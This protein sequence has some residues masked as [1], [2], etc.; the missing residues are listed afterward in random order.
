[1]MAF[2]LDQQSYALPIDEIVQIIPMVTITPVPQV[3]RVVE[4]IINVHGEVLPV[5]N[6]RRHLGLEPIPRQLH[7]PILIVR[8][9]AWTAGLIVDEVLDVLNMPESQISKP[10][11]VLP[12][13]LGK[14]SV[15]SGVAYKESGMTLLL[16]AG[17]LFHPDTLE[18]LAQILDSLSEAGARPEEKP[19]EAAAQEEEPEKAK[20]TRRKRTSA[21]INATAGAKEEAE[22]RGI[23]LALVPGTG[24]GGTITKR[25]VQRFKPTRRRRTARKKDK[26]P[27]EDEP[28]EIN[29]TAGA[30]EEGKRRGIDLALVPGTGSGGTITKRDV[31]RFKPTRKRRTARKK[32]KE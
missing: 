31:Q 10:S 24:S 29:A 22:K 30:K 4:G 11:E 2:R 12:E 17:S 18:S 6:L 21:K 1:M 28:A 7:T 25:D 19:S 20:P 9:H 5:I 15:V 27:T 8:T 32:D 16:D 23:N 13:E 26:R 14:T 3:S